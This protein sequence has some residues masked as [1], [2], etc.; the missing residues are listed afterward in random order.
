MNKD[1][2]EDHIRFTM[3][4]C[5]H[6]DRKGTDMV[7]KAGMNIKEIQRVPTGAKGIAWGPCIEGHTLANPTEHCPHW[8]RKTREMGEKRVDDIEKMLQRMTLVGPVVI[9]WRNEPP[10]GKSEIIKCPVCEG[11]L[12]LSQAASNGH[13]HGRCE[14]NDCVAWME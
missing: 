8:V 1:A 9:A 11:R 3:N 4:Y 7:C 14:T 2:R 13:V 10:L 5:Q 12:H 6:Y